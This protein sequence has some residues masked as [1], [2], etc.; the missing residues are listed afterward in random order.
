MEEKMMILKMLQEGRITPEEA[1]KLLEAIE[2]GASESKASTGSKVND[3]KEEFTSRLNEMK[4]DEKL[5]KFSEKAAKFA[6]SLG[7]KAGKFAEQFTEK[8]DSERVNSNAEKFTEEFAKR[9][10]NL[11]HDITESAARFADMF[12]NQLG[13]IFDIGYEK[14]TGSYEYPVSGA[15]S[16]QLKAGNFSLRVVPGKSETVSVNI[17][18]NSNIPEF[19]LDEYFKAVIDSS[20]YTFACDLPGKSWGKIEIQVPENL[21]ALKLD[22]DN[23]KCEIGGIKAKTI[24]CT[25][26]NGKVYIGKCLSDAIEI[27]TDNGRIIMDESTARTANIRTSNAKIQIADSKLDNVNAKTT[28]GSIEAVGLGK[29][30]G[31]EA[32]YT[33]NTSNGKIYIALE[34]PAESECMLEAATTMGTIDVTLPKLIYTLDR[35]NIGMHSNASVKSENYDTSSD[36]I[37]IKAE[38]SNA[39][40]KVGI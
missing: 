24:S 29:S 13:N 22:T 40:I 28:N 1:Y 9:I 33:L 12:A 25:T 21:E 15:P 32:R 16:I 8:L 26:N 39:P 5:N 10:E 2:K 30:L 27:L 7:E 38:T 4:I 34:S 17:I 18:A 23:G 37:Y 11:G 31:M 36:R 14:Y 19:V 20:S 35:K 3:F 6:E